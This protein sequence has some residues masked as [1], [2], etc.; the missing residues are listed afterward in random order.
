MIAAILEAEVYAESPAMGNPRA[1]LNFVLYVRTQLDA[2]F[3]L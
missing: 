2:V 1:V 3:Y